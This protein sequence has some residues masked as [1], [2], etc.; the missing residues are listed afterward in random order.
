ML[1]ILPSLLGCL[2]SLK[3]L[4]LFNCPEL[5][6][7]PDDFGRLTQLMELKIWNCEIEY[8]P[9]ELMGMKNL[10]ILIIEDCPLRELPFKKAEGELDF[11]DGKCMLKLKLL[12][13]V[14]TQISELFFHGG[15]CPNLQCLLLERCSE[16]RGIE[17]LCRLAKLQFL[18]V[19]PRVKVEALPGVEQHMKSCKESDVNEYEELEIAQ[20]SGH[21]TD[22]TIYVNKCQEILEPGSLH[23]LLHPSA[24][25]V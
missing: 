19:S 12:K 6:C 7:L 22:A 1:E 21:F 16:L 25:W 4:W 9:Q 11:S 23:Y 15:V 10:E 20:M 18:C 8:L 5:K 3:E 14:G 2:K 17:G 13:L 24:S